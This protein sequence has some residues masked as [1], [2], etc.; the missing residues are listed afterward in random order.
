MVMEVYALSS[1]YRRV[2]LLDEYESFLWTERYNAA[3]DFKMVMRPS[4]LPKV[5]LGTMISHSETDRIMIVNKVYTHVDAEGVRV[6][7][8]SGE[9][10]EAFFKYRAIGRRRAG[11]IAEGSYKQS[12]ALN[13][14]V[15]Q[16]VQFECVE[17][18]ADAGG[19]NT[20]DI[21]P[22]LYTAGMADPNIETHAVT[23]PGSLYDA[24][25]DYCDADDAGFRIQ[26]MSDYRLRFS[27]YTG[28]TKANVLFN[29]HADTL[30]EESFLA[31]NENFYDIAYVW[32]KDN[33]EVHSVARKGWSRE[34]SGLNRRVL[35][36]NASKVDTTKLLQ[37][38]WLN[39]LTWYG[40]KA[41]AK[42]N[43]E[44]IFDGKVTDINPFKYRRD[45]NLG[46]K[47]TLKDIDTN[48]NNNHKV[49]VVEYIW[50]HDTAGYRSYPTFKDYK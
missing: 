15:Q 18:Y 12:G 35:T 48:E 39:D 24:V 13:N 22:G 19:H 41:L 16:L 2:H 5:H 9:S 49:M 40:R 10:F 30:E 17:G 44:Y 45:Y 33:L 42:Q 26:L 7:E 28:T 46:D 37:Q 6:M 11:S 14:V 47:V 32:A 25:K 21:I 8:V 27:V 38:D 1:T 50:S 34:T 31:T 36:V 43:S 3:G 23:Q 20:N 29:A 4:W